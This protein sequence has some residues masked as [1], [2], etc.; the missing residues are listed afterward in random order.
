MHFARETDCFGESWRV[1]VLLGPKINE[2]MCEHASSVPPHSQELQVRREANFSALQAEDLR[3]VYQ[4]YMSLG[5][6]HR[7]DSAGD[8]PPEQ[9]EAVAR[10]M[11]LLRICDV[12]GFADNDMLLV[13]QI[14]ASKPPPPMQES[15]ALFGVHLGDVTFGLFLSWMRECFNE[16]VGRFQWNEDMDDILDGRTGF[17][18]AALRD[19]LLR[20][21]RTRSGGTGPGARRQALKITRQVVKDGKKDPADTAPDGDAAR[22][23]GGWNKAQKAWAVMQ[24][25]SSKKD[26]TSGSQALAPAPGA[27]EAPSAS[28]GQEE[29]PE[30]VKTTSSKEASVRRTSSREASK[31][32]RQRSL[33][34]SGAIASR[35][36][37]ASSGKDRPDSALSEKSTGASRSQSRSSTLRKAGSRGRKAKR[38]SS[39]D[40][41][42]SN[43]SGDGGS[44]GGPDRDTF[45]VRGLPSSDLMLA[46]KDFRALSPDRLSFGEG[47]DMGGDSLGDGSGEFTAAFL[48]AAAALEGD[49]GACAAEVP[50]APGSQQDEETGQVPRQLK[51]RKMKEKQDT[52]TVVNSAVDK[53]SALVQDTTTDDTASGA[54]KESS[55]EAAA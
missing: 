34:G 4:T 24:R 18:A 32:M 41:A 3:E 26:V 51:Q 37:S 8:D 25:L 42:H 53:L 30:P 12:N 21:D 11:E 17:T 28:S 46:R 35:R 6:R 22:G 55:G 19:Q 52:H 16:Q 7:M 44:I 20:V 45:N 33:Q 39:N 23:A 29:F 5:G 49:A 15:D 40:S 14:V 31:S 13:R 10:L 9:K 54:P 36:S 2:V 50:A 48:E 43:S 38:S 47:G 27:T 1:V